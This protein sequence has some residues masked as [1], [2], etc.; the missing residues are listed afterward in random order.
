MQSS[1]DIIIVGAGIAGATLACALAKQTSLSIA[2]LEATSEMPSWAA[3]H[4]HHRVSAIT[5]SSQR[6][7]NALQLWQPIQQKRVSPFTHIVVRDAQGAG[8]ICFDSAAIAEPVLGHI[9]ENN[10]IQAT[11][12]DK[13]KQTSQI[14]FISPIHRMVFDKKN[15]GVALD[16]DGQVMSAK[17]IIAADGARSW[18]REQAGITVQQQDYNQTAIVAT[19]RTA[20]PHQQTARQVFLNTGPLAFLPLAHMHDVSIVWSVPTELANELQHLDDHQFKLRLATAFSYELGDVLGTDRRYSFPLYK[21]QTKHYVK[22]GIALIGDAAHIIHPLAGQGV[23][24]GLLDAASLAEVITMAIHQR[25]DF[26]DFSVL[27]H[28]ERWRKAD[29]ALLT[30][31]IDM[32]KQLFASDKKIIQSLRSRGIGMVNNLRSVKNMCMHWA[33]GDRNGLP[34]LAC[35]PFKRSDHWK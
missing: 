21:Q 22:P 7:F 30:M 6:I 32:I 33:C 8:K 16:I 1:Y 24:M 14:N 27:R 4:Y 12:Y 5:L 10:L 15:N 11:L 9:V 31:G 17:L 29:N 28:Y 19:V 13:I 26:A 3:E 35:K 18:L 34:I 20:L 23:N 2:L 25:R